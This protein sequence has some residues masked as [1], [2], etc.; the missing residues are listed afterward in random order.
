MNF[1]AELKRRNVLRMAGLYLVALWLVTQ[2]VDTVLTRL[3]AAKSFSLP[4]DLNDTPNLIARLRQAKVDLSIFI[5]TPR[6]QVME[7]K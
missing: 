4:F 5:K 6:L 7:K 3:I 1:F 2:V